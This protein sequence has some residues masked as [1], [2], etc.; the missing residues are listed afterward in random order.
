MRA[1]TRLVF[2]VVKVGVCQRDRVMLG[3]LDAAVR[4]AWSGWRLF[5]GLFVCLLN[6]VG[7]ADNAVVCDEVGYVACV[8]A[9]I[10]NV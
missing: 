10:N 3:S 8:L 4:P 5:V 1:Q 2:V 9:G 6:T 7:H